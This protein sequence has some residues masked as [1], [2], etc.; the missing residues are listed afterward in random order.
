MTAHKELLSVPTEV[1][2]QIPGE[3]QRDVGAL[4]PGAHNFTISGGHFTSNFTQPTPSGFRQIPLGDVDLR[5]EICLDDSDLVHIRKKPS[6]ARRMYSAHID[7][8]ASNMTVVLY[9]GNGA[10]EEWKRDFVQ[11]AR[12]RHPNFVQPY[13]TVASCGLYATIFHDELVPFQKYMDEPRSMLSTVHLYSYFEHESSNAVDYCSSVFG[14]DMSWEV[15]EQSFCGYAVRPAASALNTP[16]LLHP[17][18][19]D[20]SAALLK[21][22]RRRARRAPWSPP[23]LWKNITKFAGSTSKILGYRQPH[24]CQSSLGRSC[25]IREPKTKSRLHTY[26]IPASKRIGQAPGIP[27]DA[28]AETTVKVMD[29]EFHSS[30]GTI[31]SKSSNYTINGLKLAGA[32]KS[33][34]FA[35][36]PHRK[37]RHHGRRNIPSSRTGFISFGSSSG[38]R[39][40]ISLE[41]PQSFNHSSRRLPVCVPRRTSSNRRRHIHPPPEF[42][43]YWSLDPVGNDRLPPAKA[44]ELGFPAI[45]WTRGVHYVSWDDRVYAGLSYFHAAKGFNPTSQDVARHM[46]KE[47]Y[48]L[49][50]I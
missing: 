47:L 45:E 27:L 2:F 3:A 4:F 43:A 1:S 23:S 33:H 11:C 10:E 13:A 8:K 50:D 9:Q 32:S 25:S 6:S 44:S 40:Q 7:G 29:N 39:G 35:T 17:Q 19:A 42:S 34:P 15:E 37:L 41:L 22:S 48:Q 12:L 5:N 36:I 26:S 49:Y 31:T 24:L 18:T 46:G 38:D 21:K 14:E 20:I 28:Y 16:L 30:V